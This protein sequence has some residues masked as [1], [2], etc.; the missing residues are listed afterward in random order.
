MTHAGFAALVAM[1]LLL[2]GGELTASFVNMRSTSASLA[3]L[4]R[5][6]IFLLALFG[7]GAKAGIV[8][9]HIWLPMAHPVAPSHV[10]AICRRGD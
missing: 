1:F 2:S 5:D 4:T 10:S 6:A 9:L 3:P 8:P 7:F